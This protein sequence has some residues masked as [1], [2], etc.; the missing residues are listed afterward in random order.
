MSS[1]SWTP[2]KVVLRDGDEVGLFNHSYFAGGTYTNT[3]KPPFFAPY[4][5]KKPGEDAIRVWKMNPSWMDKLITDEMR[6]N[7]NWEFTKPDHPLQTLMELS[8][9]GKA[10]D[11]HEA[12]IDT[13]RRLFGLK[14]PT[15]WTKDHDLF[16]SDLVSRN[17]GHGY[18]DATRSLF[19]T[20]NLDKFYQYGLDLWA[21][22]NGFGKMETDTTGFVSVPKFVPAVE[23]LRLRVKF[24]N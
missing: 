16:I 14:D 9:Q 11:A 24:V 8:D 23:P 2:D 17:W 6:N 19:A 5:V 3:D 10:S 13:Y 20:S 12:Q 7:A 18:N 15:R 1:G 22:A 4:A 21:T